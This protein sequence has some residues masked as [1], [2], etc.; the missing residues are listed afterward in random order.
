MI[1]SK[2]S[3]GYSP[4]YGRRDIILLPA[5]K[6]LENRKEQTAIFGYLAFFVNILWINPHQGVLGE[7]GKCVVGL[8]CED[9]SVCKE[10]NAWSARGFSAQIPATVKQFPC[11]L[12]SNQCF[13]GACSECKK[14]TLF[15]I[16]NRF[17]DT[18]DCNVT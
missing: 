3:G 7:R 15:F 5:H 18:V 16:G 12:K 1:K 2:K 11:D 17:E 4:K 6:G 10:E 13:S 9:V 8:I 14:D